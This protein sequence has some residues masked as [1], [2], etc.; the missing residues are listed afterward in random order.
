M[1]KHTVSIFQEMNNGKDYILFDRESI[2]FAI[3]IC[4]E[5]VEKIGESV[6]MYNS[7]TCQKEKIIHR[8]SPYIKGICIFIFIA[9]KSR[10]NNLYRDDPDVSH[11]YIID[12]Y[13]IVE[14]NIL[15]IAGS[16]IVEPVCQAYF[17]RIDY[18]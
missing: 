9:G 3:G 14:N 15:K 11:D 18:E 10:I 4:K 13:W 6:R 7:S 5:V 2:D 17:G 12:L 1:D 16:R 8:S